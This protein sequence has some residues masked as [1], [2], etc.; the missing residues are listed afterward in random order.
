MEQKSGV[1]KLLGYFAQGILF[2]VPVA[3]TV[4]VI[5][6]LFIFID[7]IIPFK[8]PGLGLLV[9]LVTKIGRAS[10]RERV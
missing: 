2:T 3:V 6:K 5:Y 9:L 8:I 4:Y 7:G 10:C 1:K